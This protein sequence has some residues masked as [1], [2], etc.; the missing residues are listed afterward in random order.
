MAIL[1]L[2]MACGGVMWLQ[3]QLLGRRALDKL[4]YIRRFSADTCHA[5][6]EIEMVETI[7]NPKIMPVPWLRL[8][9]LLPASLIFARSKETA[10]SRGSIYQNHASLFT[11]PPRTRITRTY[12]ALC[13][14]RGVFTIESVTMTGSD[15]FGMYTPSRT[16]MLNKRLVVYPALLDEV[17]LPVS[18]R[19][20]QGELA[21]RRWIVEDP[22][23]INGLREYAPG[24][25]MNRIH[26]KASAR[27]GELLVHRNGYTAD[28][29]VMICLNI[30]ESESMWSVVTEPE[31]IEAALS[32]AATLA[33]SLIHQ[34]MAA[35]FGH[36]AYCTQTAG[37]PGITEP[38]RVEPGFGR[39]H[40]EDVLEAMAA[41]ELKARMPFYEYL[42]LEVQ[43]ESVEKRDYLLV[44]RHVSERI[45]Q[46]ACRLQEA[47][48]R[49][50]YV[51]RPAGKG[52][53]R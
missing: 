34:G 17:E 14:G 20:W 19:T 43:R 41:V 8:E 45:E 9:A 6:D 50:S 32:C 30:E 38:A 15:L 48:H 23:V 52:G 42:A 27:A 47:G 39:T 26:W 51:D 10:I 4:S 1:W 24:D 44:T 37:S 18:W 16:V 7:A 11:L 21:V 35:G 36:N 25:A 3:G 12:R 31:G 2:L 46:A 33:A 49:V 13:G 22:F 5:G 28:P 53:V 29:R 40:L